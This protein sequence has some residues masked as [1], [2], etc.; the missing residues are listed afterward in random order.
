MNKYY[1]RMFSIL[2]FVFFVSCEMASNPEDS[3]DNEVI[4]LNWIVYTYSSEVWYLPKYKD[5]FPDFGKQNECDKIDL[6][7]NDFFIKYQVNDT[8]YVEVFIAP[9]YLYWSEK[10]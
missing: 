2:I 7:L 4:E 10:N 3:N 8:S 9:N 5:Q 1:F 6:Y